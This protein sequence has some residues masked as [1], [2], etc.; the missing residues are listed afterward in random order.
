MSES[1]VADRGSPGADL[2]TSWKMT[3]LLVAALLLAAASCGVERESP[4]RGDDATNRICSVSLAA[5]EILFG[6]GCVERVVAVSRFADDQSYS[7]VAGRFPKSVI[8]LTADLEKI[9]KVQP[10]L[11]IVSP[12]NSQDFLSVIESAGLRTYRTQD[13]NSWLGIRRSILEIG[14]QLAV[15]ETAVEM[16]SSA[17]ARLQRVADIVSGLERPRVL[18]WSTDMVTNGDDTTIG[19]MIRR[20]GAINVAGQLGLLGV[21]QI[22]VERVLKAAPDYLL[23]GGNDPYGMSALPPA[24]RDLP[25]RHGIKVVVVPVKMLTTVSQFFVDGVETLARR[26]HADSFRGEDQDGGR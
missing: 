2:P 16:I 26:I 10:D 9:V 13:V 19:E 25:Q 21:T 1:F 12:Y 23:L 18:A 24:F 8:R 11:V 3:P 15:E 5:D 17:D 20:S 7:N 14:Q 22:S 6:L 4:Q